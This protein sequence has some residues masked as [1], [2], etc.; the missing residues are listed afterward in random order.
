MSDEY[1]K[2][3]NDIERKIL[4]QKALHKFRQFMYSLNKPIRQQ[5]FGFIKEYLENEMTNPGVRAI[6]SDTLRPLLPHWNWVQFDSMATSWWETLLLHHANCE[7]LQT[8]IQLCTNDCY[9]GP[10]FSESASVGLR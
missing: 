10:D 1:T 5:F 3:R 4:H 7:P 9:I 8:I 6:D 2:N